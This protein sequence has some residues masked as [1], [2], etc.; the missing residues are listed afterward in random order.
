[1]FN[2]INY[3]DYDDVINFYDVFPIQKYKFEAIKLLFKN[4][5]TFHMDDKEI[6]DQTI[7]NKIFNNCH[8]YLCGSFIIRIILQNK[9]LTDLDIYISS[10]DYHKNI[11]LFDK[12]KN[13]Y[14]KYTNQNNI[15]YFEYSN[16]Y[17]TKYI[18]R[19]PDIYK[20]IR[21]VLPNRSISC[22]NK[23][24]CF[25]VEH[26]DIIII[27]NK[28]SNPLWTIKNFDIGICSSYITNHGELH[29]NNKQ[30]ITTGILSTYNM[31]IT[32]WRYKHYM[33]NQ[34]NHD[35]QH[36]FTY[37]YNKLINIHKNFAN[38]L[39][40]ELFDKNKY[41]LLI[42]KKNIDVKKINSIYL[43]FSLLFESIR[44]SKLIAYFPV[45]IT[46]DNNNFGLSDSIEN[47]N[48]WTTLNYFKDIRIPNVFL[49]HLYVENNKIFIINLNHIDHPLYKIFE[50]CI[51]D[52]FLKNVMERKQYII[53]LLIQNKEYNYS[54]CCR[55]NNIKLYV[56]PLVLLNYDS[57]K[58][59]NL[60][61][62][63]KYVFSINE[64]L[65]YKLH[66]FLN[67]NDYFIHTTAY[68]E[69]LLFDAI[70][71]Y[72]IEDV[73][74]HYIL[75]Y[76][77]INKQLK[78]LIKYNIKKKFNVDNIIHEH[79][80]DLKFIKCGINNFCIKTD[81]KKKQI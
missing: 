78:R 53:N 54:D 11:E 69:I 56:K 18:I 9:Q 77:T 45:N 49:S 15:F 34:Y 73:I 38:I 23:K 12:L 42:H 75:M 1:M 14:S 80:H 5:T 47:I 36:N 25:K 6:D 20:L 81:F 61:K 50:G 63:D 19:S 72:I 59:N 8:A 21:I 13:K 52:I 43:P 35:T 58:N 7:L 41:D 70:N 27:D 66:K 46:Y 51:D 64:E 55:A 79:F 2:I 4:I 37:V 40:D 24:K 22:Y 32:H 30:E 26:I 71:L 65:M 17:N 39:V 76:N 28:F 16:Y 31:D 44:K 48:M 67:N 74:K 10:D 33:K 3:L 60:D 62:S 57:L 68:H 29:I